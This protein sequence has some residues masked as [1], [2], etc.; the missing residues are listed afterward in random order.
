[1]SSTKVDISQGRPFRFGPYSCWRPFL[2]L[3]TSI[4]PL[5]H[6]N[7]ASGFLLRN[8]DGAVADHRRLVEIEALRAVSQRPSAPSVEP[9]HVGAIE[10]RRPRQ[11]GIARQVRISDGG[12]PPYPSPAAVSPSARRR[13]RPA[14]I[15]LN[16][17][18]PHPQLPPDAPL[19]RTTVAA[20]VLLVAVIWFA[21]IDQRTLMHADEGRYAE[22]ARE[23]AVTG[24]WVTPRLNGLKYFEKPPLQYW[25]TAVTYEAFGVH[26]WT[27]RLWTALSTFLATLFV[28]YA[29]A[30]R[31]S[32]QRRRLLMPISTSGICSPQSSQQSFPATRLL[33]FAWSA[34]KTCP[35]LRNS[36]A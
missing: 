11:P 27:A 29:G 19:A 6:R 26:H 32:N 8:C 31:P 5:A 15:R 16:A 17:R 10:L 34:A 1:M 22:I 2:L 9:V 12:L 18:S 35:S 24:D 20:F 23:M 3:G 30:R 25:M 14:L 4:D 33:I 7:A 21:G 36:G 28:G 13:R